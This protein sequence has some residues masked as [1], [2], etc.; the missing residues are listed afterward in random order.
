MATDGSTP[1]MTAEDATNAAAVFVSLFNLTETPF[2]VDPTLGF[3]Q[4][5]LWATRI[6]GAL[7]QVEGAVDDQTGQRARKWL[8]HAGTISSSDG[9]LF[10]SLP[11]IP[12]TSKNEERKQQLL[13]QHSLTNLERWFINNTGDGN[14]SNQ[15]IKYA[16]LLVDG[17]QTIMQVEQ[18]VHNLNNKLASKLPDD[19]IHQTIMVSAQ[20]AI[21]KRAA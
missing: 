21:Q 16:L 1:M 17:G 12:K 7:R 19:E 11:F 18:A 5:S 2:N 14:R 6:E 15:L 13:D 9:E 10:D 3:P 8:S 20:R 4:V